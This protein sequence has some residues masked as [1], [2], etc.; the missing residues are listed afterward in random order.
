M[1]ADCV[2]AELDLDGTERLCAELSGRLCATDAV[3]FK[4]SRAMK[5]ERVIEKIF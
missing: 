1:A 4:A 2:F 3:L 5:L